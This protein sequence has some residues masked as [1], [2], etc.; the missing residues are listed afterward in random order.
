MF[1]WEYPSKY[2]DDVIAALLHDHIIIKT[3]ERFLLNIDIDLKKPGVQHIDDFNTVFEDYAEGIPD[4]L[5]GQFFEYTGSLSLYDWDSVLAGE[6]YQALRDSALAY[7]GV[8]KLAGAKL[9]DVGC[10]PGYETADF[11]ARLSPMNV[12]ITAIEPDLNLLRIAQGEF[13]QKITRRG[14]NCPTLDKLENAPQFFTMR[15]EELKF[16][17]ENFDVVYFSNILHWLPDPFLGIKEVVRVLK[18]GGIIFGG[19]GTT[20]I[21]NPYLDITARVVKGIYGYFPKKQL[22]EW[23]AKAGITS[24]KFVT[25]VNTFKAIKPFHN[26]KTREGF[27]RIRPRHRLQFAQNQSD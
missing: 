13:C 15:A 8:K 5:K 27:R 1:G 4:R 23:F 12:Q 21:T 7:T 2:V 17:D 16:P 14:I 19:Q 20:E 24:L 26:G 3:G 25:P 22:I 18:P 6:I 9:L 10:G 11:W